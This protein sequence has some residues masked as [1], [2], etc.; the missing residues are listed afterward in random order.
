[1][2]WQDPYILL[3]HQQASAIYN[4][5]YVDSDGYVYI[6][7]V[8]GRLETYTPIPTTTQLIGT[9]VVVLNDNDSY[10]PTEEVITEALL[11]YFAIDAN[12]DLT[13]LP[14]I[15]SIITDNLFTLDL[16][17]GDLTPNNI[18]VNDI[19]FK[20]LGSGDITPKVL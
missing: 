6:G 16:V 20:L 12:G 4:N 10:V 15:P 7:T 14:V 17:T 13:P 3:I 9:G 5:T 18:G 2:A 19:F 8:D 1:M 11:S